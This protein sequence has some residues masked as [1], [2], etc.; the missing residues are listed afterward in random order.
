MCAGCA[1][2]RGGRPPGRLLQP[3][4]F[5][6][7]Q[8]GA[9][10]GHDRLGQGQEGPGRRARDSC[11][12]TYP[13]S[14]ALSATRAVSAR[15]RTR[16]W[17]TGPGSEPFS[18]RRSATSEKPIPISELVLLGPQALHPVQLECTRFA[19][20]GG[21]RGPQ[22]TSSASGEQLEVATSFPSGTRSP[23][24]SPGTPVQILPGGGPDRGAVP[25]S[26]PAPAGPL[27]RSSPPC[28]TCAVGCR[29]AVQSSGPAGSPACSAS[30]SDPV[31]HWWLWRQGP[32]RLRRGNARRAGHRRRRRPEHGRH[33]ARLRR[34]DPPH[35]WPRRRPHHR[36]PAAQGRRARARLVGRGPGRGGR[37]PGWGGRCGAAPRRSPSSGEPG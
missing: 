20:E 31:N 24:T 33:R 9:D 35:R 26:R 23:R 15:S 29:V 18:S 22:S 37:G 25:S 19:D 11:S 32:V 21:R 17:P 14:T 34:G 8:A 2:G 13:A 30:T 10:G 7:V 3:T 5:V 36:A 1:A 12:S 16:P 28:T 4:C 27:T 6:E